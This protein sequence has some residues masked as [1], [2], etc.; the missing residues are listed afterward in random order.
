VIAV[1]A[2]DHAFLDRQDMCLSKLLDGYA[3]VPSAHDRPIRRLAVSS[4][5]VESG[6]VFFAMPGTHADG[7]DYIGNAVER[8]ASAVVYE[9]TGA[10][11]KAGQGGDVPL[12]AVEGLRDVLGPIASRYFDFPSRQIRV[13]G[14]TGTNGKTTVA[15]LIAQTLDYLGMPCAYF[16]TIGTGR[17]GSLEH[18]GLTTADSVSLHGML[19]KLVQAKIP[20]LSMEVSSH[21]LDQGRVNGVEFEI[22]I[23]TN[24]SHDHLD[25]HGTL[26]KYS[27]AKRKL[28]EYPGM[29][30]MVINT[31]DAFGQEVARYC[32]TET[33]AR[34]MTYGFNRGADLSP[35]SIELGIHGTVF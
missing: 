13:L 32:R 7:R 28:F 21:G 15:H 30:G 33:R 12:L 16:G 20:A 24:L 22:G 27:Q 5:D 31:D 29:L 35:T 6:D 4:R 2:P 26:E 19:G 8:R 25:Y 17:I 3:V 34:C 11:I 10:R 9:K 1:N 18:A 14:V 23:F